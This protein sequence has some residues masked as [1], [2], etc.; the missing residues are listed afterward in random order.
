MMHTE[1]D[2]MKLLSKD[3]FTAHQYIPQTYPGSKLFQNSTS[4]VQ[5]FHIWCLSVNINYYTFILI[6][7]TI[8]GRTMQIW[9]VQITQT[10]CDSQHTGQLSEYFALLG[11][12]TRLSFFLRFENLCRPGDIPL[13]NWRA[14]IFFLLDSFPA[15][16]F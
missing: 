15:A 3:S 9:E 7:V 10:I 14:E 4:H 13:F 11:R 5:V 1:S 8:S 6:F 2:K 16:N 12:L